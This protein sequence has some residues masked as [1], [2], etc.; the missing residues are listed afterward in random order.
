CSAGCYGGRPDRLGCGAGGDDR[1]GQRA[2]HLADLPDRG[3]GER[4]SRHHPPAG[5]HS[6]PDG[7]SGPHRHGPLPP[8][9]GR[10]PGRRKLTDR[11]LLSQAEQ[12]PGGPDT[13]RSAGGFHMP[14]R[15]PAHRSPPS[16]GAGSALP[17]MSGAAPG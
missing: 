10:Y 2:F 8:G 9:A 16:W 14:C 12:A 3:A 4:H 15:P 5:V 11:R 6:R 7:G 1:R 17:G 13:F